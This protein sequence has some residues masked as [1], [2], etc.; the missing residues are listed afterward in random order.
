[1]TAYQRRR[2]RRREEGMDTVANVVTAQMEASGRGA[3]TIWTIY[4]RPKDH[5]HGHI[6]RR[7]EVGR[8]APLVA[9][10]HTLAGDLDDIREILAQAGLTNI[11]RQ[12][13][14]EPQIVESWI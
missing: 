3:L 7:F 4:D 9:T 11:R 1:M 14:D 6:A 8:G 2:F 10:A 12:D 13:G 5:P